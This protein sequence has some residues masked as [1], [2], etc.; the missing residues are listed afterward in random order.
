MLSIKSVSYL[1]EL[2]KRENLED[3]IYPPPGKASTKDRVFVVCDGVGGEAKGEIASGLICESIGFYFSNKSLKEANKN[4]IEKAILYANNKLAEYIVTDPSARKMSSTLTL[5]LINDNTVMAAWCGDSRIHH[6][7][8]GKILWKSADHSLVNELIKRDEITESEAKTHPQKNVILRSLNALNQNNTVEYEA[9]TDIKPGDFI[10]LCTDGIL[11]CIDE[12]ALATICQN[13]QQNK[14]RSFLD[15]CEGNTNDNYSMYLLEIGTSS[16][17][18]KA[19]LIGVISI[20]CLAL[21]LFFILNDK[22]T[23]ASPTVN[24]GSQPVIINASKDTSIK[25]QPK[26]DTVAFVLP[27]EAALNN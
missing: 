22:T 8:N 1:N 13:K 15:Y 4:R 20:I 6:I 25:R 12:K 23:E 3:N 18:K 11:E 7:R 26:K 19:I 21:L 10:L 16:S 5:V 24:E 17:P 27:E 9:L 2:G 14:S